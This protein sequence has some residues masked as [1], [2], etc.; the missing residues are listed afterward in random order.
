MADTRNAKRAG[1]RARP[2]P[3]PPP[4][5]SKT[6]AVTP[7]A[8]PGPLAR[9]DELVDQAKAF[10]AA[11]R[12]PNTLRA[13]AADL[14]C[15]E[16]WCRAH[17]EPSLPATPAAVALYLTSLA[18]EGRKV[19]TL[20]R[21]LVAI[22]QAHKLR[23]LEPPTRD[24][25]VRELLA[26]IRRTRGSAQAGKAPAVTDA[27]RAMTATL[28]EGSLQA[29][30]DRAL[31]LVGFAGAFRRSELVGLDVTDLAFGRAGVVVTLR[32][33]KTDQAGEGRKVGVP[34][35]ASP[36]LCPVRALRAWLGEAA[37]ADGPVFRSVS[38]H[39]RAGERLSGQS[40]ALVVK[41]TARAAGLDPA[42][43]AGHSLRAGL[44][45]SAAAAGASE[46]SI[47]ATTGHRSVQMVRRYIRDGEMFRENAAAFALR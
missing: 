36:E 14:R 32:R 6:L 18:G 40:V 22:A 20:D 12:A 13:Y 3:T 29:A 5:V 38:R 28:R 45:T 25:R 30:R 10:V 33:S 8:S 35:G 7:K 34:F 43:Y 11:A 1:G 31:L 37:I 19:A 44:A 16:G 39:G 17:G 26:G 21:R 2:K 27:L 42:L 24:A 23:G 15:F 9:R 41:R 47:M 46:R 4:A